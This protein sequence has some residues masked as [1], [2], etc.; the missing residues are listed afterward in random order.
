MLE[1][2]EGEIRNKQSR[3]IRN[4]EHTSH[5]KKPNKEE[6]QHNTKKQHERSLKKTEKNTCLAK[7]K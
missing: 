4:M 1:K 2:R 6:T 3:D 7:N 5:K